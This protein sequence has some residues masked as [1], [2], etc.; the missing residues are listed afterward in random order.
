MNNKF[1]EKN[2]RYVEYFNKAKNYYSMNEYEDC[3][4]N[5]RKCIEG[6][7]RNY[8]IDCGVDLTGLT[9]ENMIDVLCEN[10]VFNNDDIG[11]LHRVRQL[12][13]MGTHI[14][15]KIPTQYD[16][17][18]AIVDTEKA[19]EV[20]SGSYNEEKFSDVSDVLNV[21]MVN[22]DYYSEKRRTYGK[23]KNCTTRE[24][25]LAIPE[26]VELKQKADNG[27]ISAMLDIAVGFLQKPQDIFWAD[28]QLICMPK[29][30]KW[31]KEFYNKSGY[32]YDARYYFWVVRAAKTACYNWDDGKYVPNRYI[33]TAL[34]ESIKYWFYIFGNKALYVCEVES[35]YNRELDIH[36]YEEIYKDQFDMSEKMFGSLFDDNEKSAVFYLVNL[37]NKYGFEII[38]PIHKEKSIADIKYY[39]YA[40]FY[41]LN[42]YNYYS[43]GNTSELVK[44]NASLSID[45]SDIGL[46]VDKPMLEKYIEKPN[47]KQIY[48]RMIMVAD[49]V[50]KEVLKEQKQ[51]SL[52]HF[53]ESQP[54]VCPNCSQPNIGSAK[55][56]RYCSCDFTKEN[57][58]YFPIV[59]P[60]TLN[61]WLEQNS[62]KIV[63]TSIK[64][65]CNKSFL[66]KDLKIKYH[67][68]DNEESSRLYIY[69]TSF[70]NSKPFEQ[71][72]AE[73]KA[74]IDNPQAYFPN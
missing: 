49:S 45:E 40:Q 6:V 34:L 9:I 10:E 48:D 42:T 4:T 20:F 60:A 31:G 70:S 8:C 72:K 69:R 33:S 58:K 22:P 30:K 19:L 5:C 65:Y 68:E 46:I 51:K 29:F 27:D 2:K 28:N 39:Q 1:Y 54:R 13:N 47:R 53:W 25:L 56:C 63:I 21:P 35:N 23:W 17:E 41:Y 73:I 3:L 61:R 18:N 38:S 44:M 37:I 36:E 12:G 15:E 64:G 16:A 66:F 59:S 26:Y 43:K 74:I 14:S 50:I 57:T 71:Q 62:N 67:F 55:C 52:K 7:L 11:V 24:A 32:Q